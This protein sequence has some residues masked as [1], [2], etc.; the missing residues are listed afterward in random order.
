[1]GDFTFQVALVDYNAVNNM[2]TIYG[3]K[4]WGY[5][6]TAR[7]DGEPPPPPPM[8]EPS[9]AALLGAGLAGLAA[10]RRRRKAKPQAK[11]A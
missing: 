1:M 11:N 9:S 5:R 2:I 10:L 8:P 3:G 7:D 6:Y 4:E